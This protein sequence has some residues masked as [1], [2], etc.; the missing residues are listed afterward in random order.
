MSIADATA[1]YGEDMAC[2]N[3]PLSGRIRIWTKDAWQHRN[4]NSVTNSGDFVTA[5]V[6]LSYS[7]VVPGSAN[8]VTLYVEGIGTSDYWGLD[9]IHVKVYPDSSPNVLAD[10]EVSYT[11]V[12][13]VYK[14]CAYRPY[15]C[16]RDSN[17][18]VLSRN[19]YKTD[20]TTP[21]TMFQ[22]YLIGSAAFDDSYHKLADFMGHGFARI[23]LRDPDHSANN[24]LNYWTG[25]TGL[26]THWF[27]NWS[28]FDTSYLHQSFDSFMSGQFY[29]FRSGDGAENTEPKL[30]K[31]WNFYNSANAICQQTNGTTVH[32]IAVREFRLMPQVAANLDHYRA[33]I[34]PFAGYGLD[35]V[36]VGDADASLESLQQSQN[37]CAGCGTYVALLTQYAGVT[38]T[39]TWTKNLAMPIIPLINTTVTWTAL[40][41]A[42]IQYS[43]SSSNRLD[44]AL[45]DLF[46][47]LVTQ[48]S[49]SFSNQYGTVTDWGPVPPSGTFWAQF[50]GTNTIWAKRL[51]F[52]DPALIA[53][54]IDQANASTQWRN[55][56]TNSK[57]W[58]V[59]VNFDVHSVS[60]MHEWR[61]AT[62]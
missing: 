6:P 22:S 48:G 34:H 37:S 56:Q 51:H 11:V 14:V 16:V 50:V 5:N 40:E 59:T 8:Q 3:N 13:C 60:D 25:Q 1:N 9:K 7:S 41:S 55:Q 27:R 29:W 28:V 15:A 32:L 57:E 35:T 58:G 42:E 54:W 36:L 20:Y 26:D 19:V 2:N 12:R 18:T 23:E 17:L 33:K 62:P 52:A 30:A 46:N 38:N 24:Q 43:M 61:T 49:A 53:D 39:T 47:T 4:A 10:D 31:I 21:F 45:N 44:G